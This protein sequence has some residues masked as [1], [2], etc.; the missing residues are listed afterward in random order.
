MGVGTLILFIAFLLVA[1]LASA[2]LIVT[3]NSLQQTSY[4]T[5]D[6]VETRISTNL[7]VIQI[8]AI[9]GQ[10]NLTDFH[11]I[12][13]L[14]PGSD[15]IQLK[16]TLLVFNTID[17]TANLIYREENSVC[18]HNIVNG[19]DT[20]NPQELDEVV[21]D[22]IINLTEDL[23]GDG[24]S[25]FLYLDDTTIYFNLSSQA[26]ISVLLSANISDAS[27]TP[28][29]ISLYNSPVSNITDTFAYV[30]VLGTTN[31]NH[32]LLQNMTF[33]I[34]PQQLY[35]GYFSV[36]Y[37]NEGTNFREGKIQQGDVV[38][39]CYEAPR[40]VGE[41]EFVRISIIPKTGTPTMSYFYTPQAISDCRVFLYP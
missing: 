37:E 27:G 30:T 9:D 15:P 2:V 21:T 10:I 7:N 23:D 31:Q 33:L 38:R 6:D 28:V 22:A 20:Y 29:T 25:D 14:S 8:S 24:L 4:K 3:N 39:F 16:D 36:I 18:E 40:G 41:D 32:T 26:V 12:V 34:V 35:R 5:G 13:K 17:I 11:Q 19:Y 1:A